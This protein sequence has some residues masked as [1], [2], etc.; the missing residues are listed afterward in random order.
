MGG[1]FTLSDDSHGTDHVGLNY[2]RVLESV[3]CAGITELYCLAPKSDLVHEHDD[4]FVGVGWQRSSL[5]EIQR[6]KF[7]EP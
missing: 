6:H 4:R 3:K 1:R 5:N 2:S 7:W